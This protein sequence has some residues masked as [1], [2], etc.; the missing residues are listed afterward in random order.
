V[1]KPIHFVTKKLK[2]FRDNRDWTQQQLAD[3][4]TLQTGETVSREEVN[5]WENNKRGVTADK[6]L[7]ISDAT[8]IPVMELVERRNA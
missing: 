1:N 4:L 2:Q 8:K 5:Y 7:A 3:F 6:A